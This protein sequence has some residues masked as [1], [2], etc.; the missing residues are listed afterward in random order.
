MVKAMLGCAAT[1]WS[2]HT[3]K[4]INTIGRSQR[5]AAR[6]ALNNFSTYASVSQMLTTINW[7]TL[8]HCITE[9][10]AVMTFK[11]ANHLIDIPCHLLQ[12]FII[13]EATIRD[14]HNLQQELILIYILSSIIN[15]N[16]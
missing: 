9:Q 5:Q 7:P 8:A 16:V 3:Q 11:I 10:K 4:D 1:V 6:F 2:S 12:L 15:Q 13:L 14:S